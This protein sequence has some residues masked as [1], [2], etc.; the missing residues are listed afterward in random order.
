LR[1]TDEFL[2]GRIHDAAPTDPVST[3]FNARRERIH[4]NNFYH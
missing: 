1:N 4:V 2:V 3:A